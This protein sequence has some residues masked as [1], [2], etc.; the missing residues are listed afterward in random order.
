MIIGI[1][2]D[3]CKKKQCPIN[4]TL[5][6]FIEMFKME[7]LFSLFMK[8]SLFLVGSLFVLAGC[9]LNADISGSDTP[10][11]PGPFD[12]F[13]QCITDSGAVFY[14]TEW[15]SHCKN[16]KALFLRVFPRST[17]SIAIKTH[18]DAVKIRLLA[19]PPGSLAM[20]LAP[21]ERNV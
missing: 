13:A 8:K 16:Q 3:D 19:I 12:E 5:A 20:V 11:E 15:C 9:P 21:V 10:A 18:P 14:G 17:L 7:P 2:E 6:F 1:T 4:I